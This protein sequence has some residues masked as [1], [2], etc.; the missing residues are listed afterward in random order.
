M[1]L[2]KQVYI[3]SV[4]TS[5]FYNDEEQAIHIKLSKLYIIRKKLSDKLKKIEKQFNKGKIPEDNYLIRKQKLAAGRKKATKKINILKDELNAL[6][7]SNTDIR[8]LREDS[9]KDNKIIGMFDSALTRTIGMKTDQVSK[10]LFVV[11]V[12]YYQILKEIIKD[13]FFYNGEKYVYFS[14]SAGQIRT[15]KGVWIKE[16]LWDKYSGALTCGLSIDE[17]N[18]KGG[19]NANKLLAYKALTA[20][21]SSQWYGFDIDRTIVVPDLETNVTAMFDYI[22]RDT[23]SITPQEMSVPIEHT[24]GCGMILPKKS[25]KCFMTRLPFVKGLLVPFAFDKFALESENTKVKDVYGKEW[26]IIEDRIEVIFTSSQFKMK[27]YYDSWEDYKDRFKANKCQAV[28]LNEEDIG[29]EANTNYQMIQTLTDVTHD[30]LDKLAK[31]TIESIEKLGNDKDTMLKVLGAT[32]QNKYKNHYQKALLLYPELLNDEHSKKI[33]KDKK[34]SLVRDAVAAKLKIN[35]RY[36]Y[37]IPD[38]Y[39]FCERLFLNKEQPEGLLING[40]VFC[41]I[42]NEGKVD[43]LRSPHLYKEHSVRVNTFNEERSKWF[44]TGGIYTS[45]FDPISRILQFDNDGD[46]GLVIQDGLFIEIAERN[47]EGIL[48]LYYEMES[49]AASQITSE[50]TYESLLLAFKANI[51][52][53]SNNITKVF[54]SEDIDLNVVKWLTAENNYI[55]DFAK[56]LYMPKRPDWAEKQIKQYIKK[57]VPNFFMEAKDKEKH[58]V[59]PI[60][61][62]T[63]NKLRKIIPNKPI[64]FEKIAGKFD[65]KLL[66]SANVNIDKEIVKEY[67]RLERSKRWLI[68]ASGTTN[69]REGKL[70]VDLHIREQLKTICEDEDRIVNV[71]IQELYAKT[72]SPN[73]TTLW[74]CYGEIILMNLRSN[75]QGTKQCD[76]CGIRIETYNTKKYCNK[77]AEEKERL[78]KRNWKRKKNGS[79]NETS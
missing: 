57:K 54:N 33:I 14:S 56:T 29:E 27:K 70:F 50:N 23:Y 31:Q 75:L 58:Q 64:R 43:I 61:D 44:I 28:K 26:D 1:K 37:L 42:Y 66:M 67:R 59:E 69:R 18:A 19:S 60:N 17:I 9:L 32:E 2:D 11:R 30:E 39:A 6:L 24:D 25:K 16:S 76:D 15:K 10:S 49:A 3:Y 34:K 4:D 12:Y 41:K 36:I 38:L 22:D 74:D 72:N 48:P 7:D 8:T 51:G 47:M 55:I 21:A 77:C 20:S 65:Y 73:K 35:G 5:S 71:L 53:V 45:I 13:G 78:R 79:E 52:E 62:S 46:K 40:E 68:R 63:V